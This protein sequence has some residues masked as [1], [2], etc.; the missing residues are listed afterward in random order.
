MGR[1]RISYVWSTF[2]ILPLGFNVS[3]PFVYQLQWSFPSG[4]IQCTCDGPLYILMGTATGYNFPKNVVFVF[5]KID[6]VL[7]NRADPD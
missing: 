5:L 4:Y 1:Q 7:P 3:F 6:F 2:K